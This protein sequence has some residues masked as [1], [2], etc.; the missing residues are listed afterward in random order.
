MA[1]GYRQVFNKW[2]KPSQFQDEYHQR[3]RGR[4]QP[5][6]PSGILCWQSSRGLQSGSVRTCARGRRHGV[7]RTRDE[8]KHIGRPFWEIN[9]RKVDEYQAKGL[10]WSAVSRVMDIPYNRLLA[11]PTDLLPHKRAGVIGLVR[12][13]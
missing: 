9:W 2:D 12:P 4:R 5:I 8:G 11:T 13:T 6:A 7:A 1:H 3:R 10:S